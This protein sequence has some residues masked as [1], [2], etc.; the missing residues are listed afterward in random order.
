MEMFPKSVRNTMVWWPLLPSRLPHSHLARASTNAATCRPTRC[1]WV[2]RRISF[3][4]ARVSPTCSTRSYPLSRVATST[5]SISW[6]SSANVTSRSLS[7]IGSSSRTCQGLDEKPTVMECTAMQDLEGCPATPTGQ[8]YQLKVTLLEVVPRIWRR[9]QVAG[10]T[11]LSD[12]H[13]TL[14]VVMGWECP[15]AL[16]RNQQHRVRYWARQL[17]QGPG[18]RAHR[19]AASGHPPK[20]GAAPLER[21]PH[22]VLLRVRLR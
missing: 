9:F 12:L 18:T 2:S 22:C 4:S 7:L 10:S 11:K 20:S 19:R 13:R 17:S 3:D 14:Q 6:P 8:I 15:P 16:L 1:L 5:T 21:C